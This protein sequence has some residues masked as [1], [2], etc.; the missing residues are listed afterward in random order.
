MSKYDVLKE[1]IGEWIEREKEN[2]EEARQSAGVN[3]P[4][5]CMASGAIE[6]FRQVL[7]DIEEFERVA[8]L[9]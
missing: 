4:G 8:V 9:S 2:F 5:A 6:A 3:C 7:S 1:L